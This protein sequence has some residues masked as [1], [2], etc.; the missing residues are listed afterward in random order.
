MSISMVLIP[1]ALVVKVAM[2]KDSYNDWIESAEIKMPT[3]FIDKN[4]LISGL[5]AAGYKLLNENGMLKTNLDKSGEL[6]F[7]QNINGIWTAL[8]SK[9]NT[10]EAI[11]RFI[12][13]IENTLDKRT[14]YYS[15]D[16]MKELIDTTEKRSKEIKI[17]KIEKEKFPTNFTEK[18]LLI[19][20]LCE[21]GVNVEEEEDSLKCC[22]DSYNFIFK[23]HSL[24]YYEVEIYGED[25]LRDLYYH[26]S[27]IDTE[28][29]NNT[30]AY[31]YERILSKISE[32]NM[33]IQQEEILEDDSIVLTLEIKE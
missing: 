3:N 7:W 16:E 5:N 29:K 32:S 4:D 25:S 13:I 1:L 19:K 20:T 14:F 33:S 30:Q 15:V 28:Y 9:Y 21:Y 8:F 2:E 31:T 17:P 11:T 18:D 27:N 24:P 10:S 23:K 6:V 26:L 22:I 12:S